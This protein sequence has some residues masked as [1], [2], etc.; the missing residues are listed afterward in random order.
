MAAPVSLHHH[1]F[2]TT[3]GTSAC[4]DSKKEK[5]RYIDR[6]YCLL[7]HCL[8]PVFIRFPSVISVPL[9]TGMNL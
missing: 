7:F 1:S 6:G 5:S 3:A 8:L 9:L 4:T 2:S